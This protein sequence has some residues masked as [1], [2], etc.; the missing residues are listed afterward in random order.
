MACSAWQVVVPKKAMATRSNV[1][2]ARRVV[3]RIA[4]CNTARHSSAGH[5]YSRDGITCT[6]SVIWMLMFLPGSPWRNG[7]LSRIESG[8]GCAIALG[9]GTHDILKVKRTNMKN[10]PPP[11]NLGP[12]I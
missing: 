7:W 6:V 4:C 10:E 9:F 5:V 8:W 3:A 2:Q 12:A 1:A 11:P